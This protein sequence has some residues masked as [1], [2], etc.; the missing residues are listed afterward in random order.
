[1]AKEKGNL[2]TAEEL[3]KKAGSG[4]KKPKGLPKRHRNTARKTRMLRSLAK[5]PEK[6]VRRVLRRNGLA[7][8]TKYMQEGRCLAA[9]YRKACHDRK[10]QPEA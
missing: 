5:L 6:K 9:V 2:P 10:L 7:A 8:A 3:A 4:G 1:M